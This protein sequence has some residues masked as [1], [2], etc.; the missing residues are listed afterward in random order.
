MAIILLSLVS[1]CTIVKN[2]PVNKP[3]V[4]ETNINVIG[5]IPADEKTLLADR[6]ENQ[7]D[8]SLRPRA[9]NRLLWKVMKNP[10]VYD[11]AN[12]DKSVL[13]MRTLLGPSRKWE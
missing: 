8:D 6:L 13:F 12:A 1:S 2:Y 3:Y 7:L 5:D 10:P 11:V 4:T 9:L